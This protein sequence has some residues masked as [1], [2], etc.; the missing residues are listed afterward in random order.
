MGWVRLGCLSAKESTHTPEYA[1][2]PTLRNVHCC[3]PRSA[4][5]CSYQCSKCRCAV[6]EK[7]RRETL[8]EGCAYFLV[9]DDVVY[10]Q[11]CI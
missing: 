4:E 9:Q 1:D 8:L 2:H 3:F 5:D 10:F 6:G 7:G 11:V